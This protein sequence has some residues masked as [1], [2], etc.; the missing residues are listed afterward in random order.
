MK[1]DIL[2]LRDCAKTLRRQ[3]R[4]NYIW[5]YKNAGSFD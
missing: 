2:Y 5:T 1:I 4:A 3:K